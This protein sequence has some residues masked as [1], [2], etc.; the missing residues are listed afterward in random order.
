MDSTV[1]Y[2]DENAK[3]FYHNT[4]AANMKEI[5]SIFLNH[6]PRN[7]KILDVGC[8]FGR[9]SKYFLDNGYYVELFDA[10]KELCKLAQDYTGLT[11]LNSSF[12]D[13]STST[14]FN[15]IWACASLLHVKMGD[16]IFIINKY[17]DLLE[18]SGVMYASWKL[19]STTREVDGKYYSDLNEDWFDLNKKY[20]HGKI[21]KLWISNDVRENCV[22]KWINVIFRK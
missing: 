19:G 4:K 10:S 7:S 17:I 1:K 3:L 22:D 8:G 12:E 11:V 18:K 6:I 21:E 20:I 14:K 9:D 15:G 16:M 2:Y 5:Y 13:F